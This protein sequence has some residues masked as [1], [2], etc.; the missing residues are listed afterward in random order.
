MRMTS[1]R[2]ESHI[3]Q[4]VVWETRNCDGLPA[5]SLARIYG[6]GIQAV[7]R[8]SLVTLSRVTVKVVMDRVLH[9]GRTK[10]AL[11][12]SLVLEPDYLDFS[13]LIDKC[14]N[15]DTEE[16]RSALRFLL[17]ELL[18]VFGNITAEVLTIPLHQ[19]LMAVTVES[20]LRISNSQPLREVATPKSNRGKL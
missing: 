20:V 11:L 5:K 4:V 3:Q 13:Q 15:H 7:E 19:E 16:L 2:N 14:E 6:C 8:R 18:N 1:Q 10:F 9:E 17:V 12:K